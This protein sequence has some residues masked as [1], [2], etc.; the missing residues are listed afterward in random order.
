[1][2]KILCCFLCIC[3]FSSTAVPSYIDFN[4]L[5]VY[6]DSEHSASNV[7]IITSAKSQNLGSKTVNTNDLVV[8][9][10]QVKQLYRPIDVISKGTLLGTLSQSQETSRPKRNTILSGV[11][12]Y[13]QVLKPFPFGCV[14]CEQ[15]EEW[16]G[17][18]CSE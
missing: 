10:G 12:P 4:N 7:K 13:G 9:N 11:C 14:T 3:V 1:M 17:L 6:R 2:A 8:D 15:Y 5:K 18:K 16:T